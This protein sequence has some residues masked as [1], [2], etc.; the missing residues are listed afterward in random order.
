MDQYEERVHSA[1]D[2]VLTCLRQAGGIDAE[3]AAELRVALQEAAEAWASSDTVTKSIASL[4][5]DLASGIEACSYAYPG[6]E[7]AE[8]RLLA[9]EVGDLVRKCVAVD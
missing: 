3:A 6:P 9:D 8:I 5:V 2:R 1:A 7:S 4:F